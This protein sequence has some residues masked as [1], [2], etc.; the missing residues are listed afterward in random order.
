MRGEIVTAVTELAELEGRLVAVIAE[1]AVIEKIRPAVRLQD[2]TNP[3]VN[4][5]EMQQL[6]SRWQAL[7]AERTE[8]LQRRKSLQGQVRAEMRT[9]ALEK[10]AKGYPEFKRFYAAK[11]R[12]EAERA[13]LQAAIKTAKAE[14]D[15]REKQQAAIIGEAERTGNSSAAIREELRLQ[16]LHRTAEHKQFALETCEAELKQAVR[17]CAKVGIA[18]VSSEAHKL[19]KRLTLADNEGWQLMTALAVLGDEFARAIPERPPVRSPALAFLAMAASQYA[20]L[21]GNPYELRIRDEAVIVG[22][23]EAVLF[24]DGVGARL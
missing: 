1:Q 17:D 12:L 3:S 19:A 8:L 20:A 14:V 15:E 2:T 21:G 23:P 10:L 6:V 22:G 9:A 4:R 18:A 16:Q 7:E 11:T 13:E 24:G 5:P